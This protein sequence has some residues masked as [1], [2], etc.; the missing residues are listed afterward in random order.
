MSWMIKRKLSFL[1]TKPPRQASKAQSLVEFAITLPVIFI[2]FTG[3][4]EF[5][6]ALNFYLSIMDATR[7]AARQGADWS[8]YVAGS[9]TRDETFYDNV[10]GETAKFLDPSLTYGGTYQG[11]KLPLDPDLDDVIVSVYASCDGVIT[12]VGNDLMYGNT[13]TG[14]SQSTIQSHLVSG[15]PASGILVVEVYYS[16]EQVLRLPWLTAFV[17]DPMMLRAY[18]IM[19][20]R[21]AEPECP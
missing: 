14:V 1:N 9:Y 4:V 20:L 5:G 13:T 6:F 16:Y 15:S 10:L 12:L 11:R 2:L 17:P 8:P 19:P 3:V 21:A 18:S 7:Y